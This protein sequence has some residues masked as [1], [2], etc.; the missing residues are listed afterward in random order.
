MTKRLS[1]ARNKAAD[2]KF[3]TDCGNIIKQKAEMCVLCGVRQFSPKPPKNRGIAILLGLLLGGLGA[4]KF[5]LGSPGWGTLYL[6]FFWTLIP[7]IIALI[8]VITY[9]L[10]TDENF[11]IKYG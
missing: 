4:H 6:L 9:I 1:V 11:R 10:T 2:E 5:Y 8:D 3:C 7:A